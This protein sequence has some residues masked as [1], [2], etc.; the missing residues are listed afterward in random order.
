[1]NKN[2]PLKGIPTFIYQVTL[3]EYEFQQNIRRT[4][5]IMQNNSSNAQSTPANRDFDLQR[6]FN[7]SALRQMLKCNANGNIGS[8]QGRGRTL[9][10]AWHFF[11]IRII[12]QNVT[13]H[14]VKKRA[15]RQN[16]I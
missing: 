1:M 5:I 15:E 11:C 13:S 16:Q 14:P 7:L 8:V 4:L 3:Q 9:C 12:R 6:S 2:T 10:D